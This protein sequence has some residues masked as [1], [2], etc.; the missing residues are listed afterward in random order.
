ME[1]EVVELNIGGTYYVTTSSTL[2]CSEFFQK[3]FDSG[4]K[5]VKDN[6][7][8]IFIDRN[9][10]YFGILLSIIRS[11]SVR[12]KPENI[13][14]LISEADFYD[15]KSVKK[16][17]QKI[18]NEVNN[19]K[20]STNDNDCRYYSLYNPQPKITLT[21]NCTDFKINKSTLFSSLQKKLIEYNM[22]D[23]SMGRCYDEMMRDKNVEKFYFD[24]DPKLFKYI[25]SWILNGVIPIYYDGTPKNIHKINSL[26]VES[27]YYFGSNNKLSIDLKNLL[28]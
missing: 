24:G 2:K 23:C 3:L 27:E 10:K 21:V 7:G 18:Q 13:E 4:M 22:N 6:K 8:R 25:Y 17:L 11:E 1:T 20:V 16:Y 14:N 5:I 28:I 19:I 12:I 9:G 26:I 15:I